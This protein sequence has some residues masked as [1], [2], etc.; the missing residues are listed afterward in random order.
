MAQISAQYPNDVGIRNHPSVIYAT[1]FESAN[2][3][4]TDFPSNTQVVYL[5]GTDQS[6]RPVWTG[7]EAHTGSG[8]LLHRQLAGTNLP[9]P[10]LIMGFQG[11]DEIYMRWYRKYQAGYRW[12][13]QSAKNNGVYAVS[14]PNVSDACVQ[15]TGFDKYSFRVQDERRDSSPGEFFGALYSY[16]PHAN[17][18]GCGE[19]YSQNVGGIKNQQSGV[20]TSYEIYIKANTVGQWNGVIKMWVNGDLRGQQQGIEFR[21]TDQLKINQLSLYGSTGGCSTPYTQDAWDDNLV[22]A[23]EYIGP[24]V[25]SPRPTAPTNLRVVH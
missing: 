5:G 11:V 22:V 2:W 17:N 24:M 8:A 21:Y 19:W 1:G 13:C 3:L 9:H 12:G 23:K 15:P 10:M 6:A 25:T 20:W 14:G 7:A 16:H 4:A 18:G